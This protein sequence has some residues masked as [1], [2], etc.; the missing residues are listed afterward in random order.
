MKHTFLLIAVIGLAFG[1]VTCESE[2]APKSLYEKL[3]REALKSGEEH[4]DLFF[5][6]Y[7]GMTKDSFLL[8]CAELNKDT[9]LYQGMGGKVEHEFSKG[10]L[11]HPA[12]MNFYPD[13]KDEKIFKTDVL[14]TYNN[15]APWNKDT[16]ATLLKERTKKMMMDW[17]GGNEF[18]RIPHPVDTAAYVKLDGN[19]RILIE[20]DLSGTQ[21]KATFTDLR[22]EA[23]IKKEIMKIKEEEEK[24]E[25]K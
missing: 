12:R 16:H 21:V 6:L 1:M 25:K 18:V 3:E 7:F 8:H 20:Q 5:G 13:F 15:W 11:K 2:E 17:Y 24:A 4:N 19:R 22:V 9:T 10:E 23:E 14:F